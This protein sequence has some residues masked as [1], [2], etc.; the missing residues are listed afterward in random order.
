M[1][2]AKTA[3]SS[4]AIAKTASAAK[5]ASSSSAIA[6]TSASGGPSKQSKQSSAGPSK[7]SKQSSTAKNVPSSSTLPQKSVQASK[8][9]NQSNSSPNKRGHRER[10]EE[11]VIKDTPGEYPPWEAP[12]FTPNMNW[13]IH[14]KSILDFIR[15]YPHKSVEKRC[16]LAAS[17]IDPDIRALICYVD[18]KNPESG[19]QAISEM[20]KRGM[21]CFGPKGNNTKFCQL[22]GWYLLLLII[23]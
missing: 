12:L 19:L 14:H 9:A 3:T 1:S 10:S 5:T 23:D 22:H 2:I 18:S 7:Q 8:A 20:Y 4:S 21:E 6:K 16:R 17:S 11:P 13:I 15:A